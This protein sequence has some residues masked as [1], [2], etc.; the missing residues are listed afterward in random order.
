MN[1]PLS[2]EMAH[3]AHETRQHL[4]PVVRRLSSFD[5]PVLKALEVGGIRLLRASWLR[6]RPADFRIMRRQDLEK[7]EEQGESPFLSARE[8]IV[9]MCRAERLLGILTYGTWEARSRQEA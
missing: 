1:E 9:L 6:E 4:S 3:L 5:D 8:A 7:L 2:I